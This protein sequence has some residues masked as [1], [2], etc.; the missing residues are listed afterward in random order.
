MTTDVAN[1]FAERSQRTRVQLHEVT[2][3]DINE[4]GAYV[5]LASGKLYRIPEDALPP[6]SSQQETKGSSRLMQISKNP[7]VGNLEAR[8][9]CWVNNINPNF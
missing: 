8:V 1:P 4:P 2:W 5:E 3:Q 9:I 6:S 7:S